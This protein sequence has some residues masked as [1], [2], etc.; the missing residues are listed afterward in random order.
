MLS[1]TVSPTPSTETLIFAS[2]P[3]A[4]N[5][6]P[7]LPK[8]NVEKAG[9][10]TGHFR[11]QPC[12]RRTGVRTGSTKVARRPRPAPGGQRLTLGL[13]AEAAAQSGSGTLPFF[14][15]FPCNNTLLTPAKPHMC[16]IVDSAWIFGLRSALRRIRATLGTTRQMARFRTTNQEVA[17]SSRAGRTTLI[18]FIQWLLRARL[19]SRNV[20]SK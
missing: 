7:S 16:L 5:T 3:F 12:L 11:L 1:G 10:L 14:L 9:N 4:A 17:R 15:P 13:W 19:L 8:M 20:G 18:P 6:N 2:H